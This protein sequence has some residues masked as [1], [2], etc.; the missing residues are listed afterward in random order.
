MPKPHRKS[1]FLAASACLLLSATVAQAGLSI[2]FI[3]GAPKDRF[4]IENTG[5]CDI[6]AATLRLDLSSSQGALIFDVT[7][8][9][10]GVEVFQPFELV[11]GQEA[12]ASVP[13]VVDGQNTLD[14]AVDRLKPGAA[15]GFTIDVDDTIGTRQITVT[16]SEIEGAKVSITQ[17]AEVTAATFNG[18][19]RAELQTTGC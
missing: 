13:A 2:R 4:Q 15:I 11:E 18:K 8:T 17:G 1:L 3:E 19:A 6:T 9:G 16:G 12:L 10:A 14:L 7:S 5:S